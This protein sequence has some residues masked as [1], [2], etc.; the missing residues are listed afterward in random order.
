MASSD[1]QDTHFIFSLTPKRYHPYWR[2]MRLDRSIG[3]WLLYIPCL[4]GLALSP[5]QSDISSLLYYAIILGSG[6]IIMRGAGCVWNDIVDSDKDKLVER[7]KERPIPKGEISIKKAL[8]FLVFLLILGAVIVIQLPLRTIL[9]SSA[10]LLLVCSY[11]FMKRIT[12]WPQIWLGLTFNWG[13][14]V[15]YSIHED[16]YF[17]WEVCFL[18][19]AAI[20]WTLGYDT[21]YACQDKEDDKKI[22]VKSTALRLGKFVRLWVAIFYGVFFSIL[23]YIFTFMQSYFLWIP[24]ALALLITVYLLK[25]FQG[26]HSNINNQLFIHNRSIGLLIFFSLLLA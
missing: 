2:L 1:I 5:Y 23:A 7:T 6:A 14:F 24:Y 13:I 15:G 22:N 12:H 8:F 16:T 21:I 26:D 9:I 17:T 11:P 4:W 20:F 10:S 25:I 3:T 18:Y 19:I